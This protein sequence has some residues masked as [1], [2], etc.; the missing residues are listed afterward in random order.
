MPSHGVEDSFRDHHA[1]GFGALCV[2]GA[3]QVELALPV[4]NANE[5]LLLQVTAFEGTVRPSVHHIRNIDVAR[6]PAHYVMLNTHA[7]LLHG[8]GGDSPH[9]CIGQLFELCQCHGC[10]AR[11]L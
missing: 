10:M 4:A 11:A 7:K 9:G 2:V 8:V 6:F 3:P 1:L 5:S